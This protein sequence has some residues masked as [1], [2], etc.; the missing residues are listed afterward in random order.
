MVDIE[1]ATAAATYRIF[2]EYRKDYARGV[3]SAYAALGY[4]GQ[5]EEVYFIVNDLIAKVGLPELQKAYAKRNIPWDA[6]EEFFGT[7]ADI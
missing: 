4:G 2:E 5:P 3:K 6:V 7:Y 1:T